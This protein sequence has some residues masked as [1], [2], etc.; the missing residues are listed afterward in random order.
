MA[1]YAGE[2]VR[3]TNAS[4][5]RDTTLVDTDV[6]SVVLTIWDPDGEVVVPET[7]M[8]WDTELEEWYYDWHSPDE[9]GK[10]R[11]RVVVEGPGATVSW[12]YLDVTLRRD[13]APA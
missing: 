2:T 8:S 12:E 6:D 9:S 11:T 7:A 4:T 5:F 10:Y 3:I 13:K 1:I